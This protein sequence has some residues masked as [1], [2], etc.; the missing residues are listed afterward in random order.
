MGRVWRFIHLATFAFAILGFLLI[1]LMVMDWQTMI[2]PD[3]FTLGGIFAWIF[4]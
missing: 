4:S 3:S 2:L 1:G